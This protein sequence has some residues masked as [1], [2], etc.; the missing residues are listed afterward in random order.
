M[1]MSRE[2]AAHM[3]FIQLHILLEEVRS[4]LAQPADNTRFCDQQSLKEAEVFLEN[5]IDEVGQLLYPGHKQKEIATGQGDYSS[6]RYANILDFSIPSAHT[7]DKGA[8][9]S[10]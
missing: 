4:L 2:Q 10:A 1:H 8:I 6:N 5:E 7:D 9:A 3:H